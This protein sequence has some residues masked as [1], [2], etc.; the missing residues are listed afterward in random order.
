MEIVAYEIHIG[1]VAGC[2]FG[3]REYEF[4]AVDVYERDFVLYIG[5]FSITLT[6]IYN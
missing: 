4:K 2:L 3:I 6:L 1:I 5:I